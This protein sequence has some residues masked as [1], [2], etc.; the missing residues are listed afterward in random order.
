MT[1]SVTS[2]SISKVH[3]RHISQNLKFQ[4]TVEFLSRQVVV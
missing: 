4:Q 1:L 2:N 3:H